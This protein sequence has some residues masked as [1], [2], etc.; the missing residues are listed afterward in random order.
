MRE[1]FIKKSFL[2]KILNSSLK[3]DEGF[4][5]CLAFSFNT[6]SLSFTVSARE[7]MFRINFPAHILMHRSIQLVCHE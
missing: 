5:H 7:K 4:P 6:L 1:D 3:R 2:R